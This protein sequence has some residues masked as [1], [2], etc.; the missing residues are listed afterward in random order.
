MTMTR[1]ETEASP[2]LFE[3]FFGHWPDLLQRP[4][5]MWPGPLGSLLQVEEYRSDGELVVR[6]EIP[7]VDPERDVQVTVEDGTLRIV[8]ERREE[9]TEEDRDYVRR[10]FRYGV[11]RRR[12]PLPEG[13]VESDIKATYTNGVLEV[14]VAVPEKT[15]PK[16]AA[17]KIAIT[18]L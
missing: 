6:A 10:E 12:L 7:G 16:P 3:R 18:T 5:L 9:E 2:D 11:L 17:R 4:M 13:A 15:A 1:K 14:R 8:A